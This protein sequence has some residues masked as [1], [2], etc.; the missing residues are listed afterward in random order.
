M[1]KLDVICLTEGKWE[2]HLTYE[3]FAA[4]QDMYWGWKLALLLIMFYAL[5]VEHAY[6]NITEVQSQ[7]QIL[8][9]EQNY[10]SFKIC[11]SE[12]G[13]SYYV[14]CQRERAS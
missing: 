11:M 9:P 8:K 5:M 12:N 2:R 1:K 14:P 6:V 10:D 7:R 13:K 4:Q 3:E